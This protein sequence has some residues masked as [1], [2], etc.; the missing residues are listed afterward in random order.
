MKTKKCGIYEI[1]NKTNGHFYIGSSSDIERRFYIHHYLLQT[2]NHH[3]AHLQ[4]AWKKYGES[5]F[6]FNV[7]QLVP[8]ESCI[9][10]EQRLLDEHFGKRYFYNVD[11]Y[12]KLND[13]LANQKRSASLTGQKRS[14]ETCQRMSVAQKTRKITQKMLDGWK[15]SGNA[16]MQYRADHK[17]E[18]EKR[19]LA[20]CVGRKQPEHFRIVMSEKMRGRVIT[21]EWRQRISDAQKGIP[22]KPRTKE[23]QEKLNAANRGLKRSDKTKEK[24]R[25]SLKKYYSDPEHRKQNSERVKLYYKNNLVTPIT[26]VK[27]YSYANLS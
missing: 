12:A 18:F 27:N 23:H 2:G 25:Q 7:L 15:K 20:A 3:N 21:E 17:E 24:L 9:S 5:V 1:R 13:D 8:K 22:K 14:T 26:S 4:R 19:R 16:L 6:E 11:K 10:E